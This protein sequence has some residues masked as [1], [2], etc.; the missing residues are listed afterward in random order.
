M[1]PQIRE[2]RKLVRSFDSGDDGNLR[3][4]YDDGHDLDSLH[5]QFAT[6][7]PLFFQG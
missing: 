1:E 7:L 4:L 5:T 6:S 3:F 2:M